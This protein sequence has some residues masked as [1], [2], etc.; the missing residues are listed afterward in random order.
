AVVGAGQP[1]DPGAVVAA[2]PPGAVGVQDQFAALAVQRECGVVSGPA[3]VSGFAAC[4]LAVVGARLVAALDVARR[5]AESPSDPGGLAVGG[6]GASV[7]RAGGVAET[8][9]GSKV[10]CGLG[11][12]DRVRPVE[13]AGL[14]SDVPTGGGVQLGCLVVAGLALTVRSRRQQGAAASRGRGHRAERHG[15]G[16]VGGVQLDL[17]GA[18]GDAGVQDA[19]VEGDQAQSGGV[20][21]AEG[22]GEVG[23]VDADLDRTGGVGSVGAL[24]P[25]QQAGDSGVLG[26][27]LVEDLHGGA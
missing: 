26:H 27:L 24:D 10:S 9:G 16:V 22:G 4:G 12:G 21:G 5:V 23:V 2:Q 1:F 18:F 15:L 25:H 14:Q 8:D 7:H 19:V 3:L 13:V 11:Y 6:G 17:G 20:V